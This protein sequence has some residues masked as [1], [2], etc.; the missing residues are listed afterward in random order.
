MYFLINM[1]SKTLKRKMEQKEISS[2]Y[3][4]SKMESQSSSILEVADKSIHEEFL[5]KL[6]RST[7]VEDIQ[8][9]EVFRNHAVCKVDKET[10]QSFSK[11]Y[12]PG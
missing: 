9:M 4:S 6:Q 12:E 2:S 10:L 8:V 1:P 11:Y 5:D 7:S 3:K